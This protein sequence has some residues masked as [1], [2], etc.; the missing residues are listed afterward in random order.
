MLKN[1]NKGHQS[2][3]PIDIE[4]DGGSRQ[5]ALPA[6]DQLAQTRPD[7]PAGAKVVG[8]WSVPSMQLGPVPSDGKMFPAASRQSPLPW[9]G[10]PLTGKLGNGALRDR[11]QRLAASPRLAAAFLR[12]CPRAQALLAQST[13]GHRPAS[14]R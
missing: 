3:V 5:L 2:A 10:A 7:Q 13:L 14:A 6:T 9:R 8:S 11:P 12:Q 1:F 4:F